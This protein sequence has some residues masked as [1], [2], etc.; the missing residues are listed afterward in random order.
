MANFAYGDLLD[1][2]NKGGANVPPKPK[3]VEV[4]KKVEE[5]HL[6]PHVTRAQAEITRL[7]K[8]NA[9]L[10]G[11]NRVLFAKLQAANEKV[12][13]SKIGDSSNEAMRQLEEKRLLNHIQVANDKHQDAVS[14]LNRSRTTNN[15]LTT[16]LAQTKA[17]VVILTNQLNEEKKNGATAREPLERRVSELT[18]QAKEDR[19]RLEKQINTRLALEK[20]MSTL[21]L[22]LSSDRAR[23]EKK[24]AIMTKINGVDIF[25][26]IISLT[27]F[28][29]IHLLN[30]LSY[31]YYYHILF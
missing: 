13:Q 10:S 24:V 29:M 6:N 17:K 3:P 9:D 26:F 19:E 20:E 25:I 21:A 1:V 30:I 5:P 4:E 14:E 8:L 27:S 12:N 28:L 23:L 15:Q 7:K 31:Y 22:S 16:D 18:K 2:L 11:E